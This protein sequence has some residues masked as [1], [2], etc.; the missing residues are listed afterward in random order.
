MKLLHTLCLLTFL[1]TVDVHSQNRE[2]HR[3]ENTNSF[4]TL[5][6]WPIADPYAP[7]LRVGYTAH[8]KGHWK[9]G[10]DAG[11]GNGALSF[12]ANEEFQNEYKLW[13]VRPEVHYILNPKSSTIKYLSAEL[14]YIHQTNV[15]LNGDYTTDDGNDIAF[16][17]ADYQ[18]QKYGMHFKFGLFLNIGKN[19]GFNF[20]GGVGFRIRDNQY[21]NTI[22]PRE[23]DIFREWFAQPNEF[24]GRDFN[25]NPAL[26][27]KFYYK[28]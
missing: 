10:L 9:V 25:F 19:L 17:Q 12:M 13:E 4:I 24:E 11:Y 21:S 18:R 1:A 16:D 2:A 5:S 15:F 20:Y 7:R 8:L 28:I 27:I 6:L 26:G 3:Q 14:F 22:N 23:T